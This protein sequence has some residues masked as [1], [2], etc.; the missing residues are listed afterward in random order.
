MAIYV[1]LLTID[2]PSGAAVPS[3]VVLAGIPEKDGCPVL[4]R[5]SAF[6]VDEGTRPLLEHVCRDKRGQ[7]VALPMLASTEASAISLSSSESESESESESAVGTVTLRIKEWLGTGRS[8]ARNP[9]WDVVGY[10]QDSEAGVVR[11]RVPDKLKAGIY[12]LSW[13]VQ[14][15]NDTA[16]FVDRGI[17]S[18]ER[19]LFKTTTA[20]I[21]NNLGPPTLQELRML[22][23][24]SSSNENLLID[25]V[26]FTDDQI[27]FAMVEPVRTWNE[28]PPPIRTFTTRNFPFRGMW[29]KGVA[30]QLHRMVANHYRRNMMTHTAA[31]VALNDKDKEREYLAE[32]QR[33][34]QEYMDWLY[35][36]KV[37]I[38]IRS[39]SGN[40]R[41][42]YSGRGF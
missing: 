5:L 24:D 11:A 26:E 42:D 34:W 36:K 33:L 18:V 25:E 1:E 41:S 3:D 15:S 29:A 39:F 7:P 22:I 16:V 10:G 27:L 32:S 14:D 6:L 8:T 28:T 38:N 17:L 21:Y 23:M 19:S 35:A 2:R 20:E 40:S 37:S 30:A 13:L 4:T 12:E 31:G 9:V